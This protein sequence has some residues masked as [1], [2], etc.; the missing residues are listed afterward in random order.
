[1][2]AG[3]TRDTVPPPGV[4]IAKDAAGEPTGLFVEHNLIQNTIG[5]NMQIK[6]QISIPAIPGMPMAPTTT[7]IRNNV[8]INSGSKLDVDFRDMQF[9][10]NT[11]Y[12]CDNNTAEGHV[13]NFNYSPYGIGTNGVV[14]NNIFAICGSD[15]SSKSQGWFGISEGSNT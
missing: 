13:I 8:F 6:D 2:R 12:N 10:N 7:I 4:E 1:V 14:I 11:F 3:V 5:Y 9:L 15:P